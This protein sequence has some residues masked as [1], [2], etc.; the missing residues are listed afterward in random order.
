M[1][2]TLQDKI[3]PDR[4]GSDSNE[5][6]TLRL[7]K[8]SSLLQLLSDAAEK[9]QSSSPLAVEAFLTNKIDE[10]TDENFLKIK[11]LFKHSKLRLLFIES[12]DEKSKSFLLWCAQDRHQIFILQ[13]ENGDKKFSAHAKRFLMSELKSGQSGEFKMKKIWHLNMRN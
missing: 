12:D 7:E 10:I 9:L 3:S 13:L 11:A 2:E 4:N 6:E 8:R 1:E 5:S